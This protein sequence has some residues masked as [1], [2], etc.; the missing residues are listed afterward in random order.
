[1]TQ[2]ASHISSMTKGVADASNKLYLRSVI[3]AELLKLGHE[4]EQ[5]EHELDVFFHLKGT[6]Q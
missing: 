2:I 4:P 5:V 1:M 6:L 3:E